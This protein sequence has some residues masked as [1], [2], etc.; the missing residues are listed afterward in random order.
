MEVTTA[1]KISYTE[2]LQ[3]EDHIDS[4]NESSKII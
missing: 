1:P 3:Q 4:D 2:V